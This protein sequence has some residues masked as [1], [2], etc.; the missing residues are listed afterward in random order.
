MLTIVIPV[1]NREELVAATLRSVAAQTLR[2]LE[3]VL[4]DNASTDGTL[5]AL[6]RWKR[7]V[8]ST[9]MHVTVVEEPHPGACSARNRGLREVATEFVMFFDSDDIMHP[10]HA[11]RAL[12][13]LIAPDRPAIVGWDVECQTLR[14]TRTLRR[15]YNRNALWHNIMHGSMA[16]QRYACR[17]S[18][19]RTAGEW[20]ADILG[21]NDMEL[22]TRLL[23]QPGVTLRKLTGP[24]T[25]TVIAQPVS[26]TGTDYSSAPEK[27]EGSLAAIEQSLNAAIP[28]ASHPIASV[29]EGR[30][31]STHGDTAIATPLAATSRSARRAIRFV[32]LRRAHLAGLYAAEG[33]EAQSS[34]LALQLLASEPCPFYRTLYRLAIAYT[35]RGGR[36]LARLLQPFF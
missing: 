22:G 6:H 1:H 29:G 28:A 32:R 7:Q 18:L 8:E 25:V 15:F 23:L 24:A 2:P 5:A 30:G 27:W 19:V 17:T 9:D 4:V 34:R 20:N 16:T 12:A 21:W 31:A 26:I 11:A 13:A 14:G 10:T 36:G 33:A 3:V 35:R